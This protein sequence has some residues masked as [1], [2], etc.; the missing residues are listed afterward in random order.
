MKCLILLDST[1]IS[2]PAAGPTSAL[3]YP[4]RLHRIDRGDPGQWCN[5]VLAEGR[6]LSYIPGSSLPQHEAQCIS[7]AQQAQHSLYEYGKSFKRR[8]GHRLWNIY[9]S[10][11]R[12]V[13]TRCYYMGQDCLLIC[14]HGQI[15]FMGQGQKNAQ[16]Q[17]ETAIVCL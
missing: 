1:P 5:T 12:A 6:Y 4:R 9:G 7:N 2:I 3:Q 11:Q 15:S 17:K 10:R 16:S 13:L 14:F 8:P